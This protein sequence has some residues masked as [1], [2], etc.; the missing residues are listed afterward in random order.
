MS[1]TGGQ[2]IRVKHLAT[3][4]ETEI[5]SPMS[6]EVSGVSFS[7]DGSYVYYVKFEKLTGALYQVPM[8][9]GTSKKMLDDVAFGQVGLSPD[10]QRVAFVRRYT[11][12]G[13]YALVSAN[14]ESGAE[15][16]LHTRKAPDDL[17]YPAW[18]PDGRVIVFAQ[19]HF[20]P[21]QFHWDLAEVRLADRTVRTI[22]EKRWWW[23]GGI[24]WLSHGE[25]LIIVAREISSP[26]IPI[27]RVS[28]PA[29]E[30]MSLTNDTNLYGSLSLAAGAQR[31]VV[32]RTEVR[33]N[34]SIQAAGPNAAPVQI[35]SGRENGSL[36]LSWTADGR[37]VYATRGVTTGET[38][39]MNADGSGKRL[40]AN[41][42]AH[43]LAISANGEMV[44]FDS[45]RSGAF[46]IW[47]MGIDGH[48]LQ[49]I[50]NGAAE[51]DP[52]F[53][54]GDQSVVYVTGT[55][56]D[57]RIW[58]VP[59]NG[60]QSRQLTDRHSHTPA[61]SPDGKLLAF[62]YTDESAAAKFKLGIMALA[63]GELQ[64]SLEVPADVNPQQLAWT[65]DGRSLSFV[66]SIG[67]VANVWSLPANG[68]KPRPVTNF[69]A[70]EII[71]FA[72]SRDGRLALTRGSLATD[73]FLVT[74]FN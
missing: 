55:V 6:A 54:A 67:G 65:P 51:F 30:A 68:G 9:G 7:P 5:V 57:S 56:D 62:Y 18:S 26:V 44:V 64:R 10:G 35:T 8:L 28:Y 4:S 43:Q 25:G 27:W 74:D 15:E 61:V 37:I 45:V 72:W 34:I 21:K 16:I 33:A 49:R 63:S 59:I 36:G 31:I 69:S 11:E 39:M 73:I 23:I 66:R 38:W 20:D 58:Q 13:E 71:H 60:G 53:S 46:N 17:S 47:R 12:R 52:A 70:D 32:A 22:A 50:T 40:I 19:T 48:N 2:S 14:L 29:G 3:L 41:V 24:A 42:G 1:D